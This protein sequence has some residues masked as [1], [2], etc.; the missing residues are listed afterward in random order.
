MSSIIGYVFIGFI[1]LL[2]YLA[3]LVEMFRR[4]NSHIN[5]FADA[6]DFKA[7]QRTLY[8]TSLPNIIPVPDEKAK[9][10]LKGVVNALKTVNPITR[11]VKTEGVDVYNYAMSTEIPENVRAMMRACETAQL[12]QLITNQNPHQTVR[13]AWIYEKGPS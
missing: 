13:C 3:H 12:D 2:I 5:G 8:Q 10:S 11:T 7:E 9:D 4:L 1:L 6:A